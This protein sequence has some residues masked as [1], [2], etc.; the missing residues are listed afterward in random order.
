MQILL[1][2]D[3]NKEKYGLT[4]DNKAIFSELSWG[5]TMTHACRKWVSCWIALVN[6]VKGNSRK[7]KI[8]SILTSKKI[9]NGLP[10]QGEH[11]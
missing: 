2:G 11:A 8:L 7:P 1:G 3:V 9:K 10:F 4:I 6:N 5:H